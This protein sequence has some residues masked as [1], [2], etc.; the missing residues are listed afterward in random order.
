MRSSIILECERSLRKNLETEK[1]QARVVGLGFFDGVHLGHGALLR[2]VREAAEE[3]GCVAAAVTFDRHP[4]DM[5]PGAERALLLNTP[6]ERAAL[7]QR[8]YGIQEL[9]VLPFDAHMRD[10]DW[11]DFITGVLV[12]KHRAVHLV[13]GH[14]Y[15]FGRRGEGDP[16]RLQALCR[17]LGLGCHIIPRVEVDG[18][19]VSST[20]IRTLIQAGDMEQAARFLGH[21]HTLSGPVIHGRALGRSLGIPTANLHIPEGVLAPAFGV[22]ACRVWVDGRSWPAVTNVGVRPTVT[23]DRRVTVESWLLDFN[24]DL[25]SETIRVDF[26]KHLRLEQ[27]FSSLAELQ[28]AIFRNADE[29]R[30]FFEGDPDGNTL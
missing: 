25:Y 30:A 16:A 15:H 8:L 22:Y 2:Q 9:I 18:V 27:K 23:N 26:L 29:T 28:A 20:H 19:T 3:R 5:I 24:G 6:E 4:R 11:R 1:E 14:D 17:E 21:P 7:M 10:M 13:A 12:K